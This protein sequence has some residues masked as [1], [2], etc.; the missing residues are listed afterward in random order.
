MNPLLTAQDREMRAI[1]AQLEL[2]SAIPAKNPNPGTA[3]TDEPKGGRR[4]PGDYGYSEYAAW[5]GAPLYE[6]T[7]QHPGCQNDHQRDECIAAAK[8]ELKHLRKTQPGDKGKIE[9]PE[10]TRRRMLK[11]TEGWTLE[12]VAQSHWRMS[13]TIMRRLRLADGR[14]ADD[15][16]P[17]SDEPE[18]ERHDLASRARAMKG[19]GMSLRQI[20][21]VLGV[22]KQQV[23][24]YLKRVA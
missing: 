12:N 14:N 3:G 11:E 22:D 8:R 24:R 15:G 20:G 2:V 7:A 18:G 6:P 16:L 10:Q 13:T 19:R 9:S 5:Y 21:T 1:L 17:F 4:P 23:Q